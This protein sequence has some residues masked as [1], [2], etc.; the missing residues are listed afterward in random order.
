MILYFARMKFNMLVLCLLFVQLFKSCGISKQVE[1]EVTKLNLNRKKLTEIPPYVYDLKNLKELHLYGNLIDSI[2]YRIGDL[3]NLEKLYIGRNN[4]KEIP[5]EIGKLKNLKILSAQYNEISSLPAEIGDL[6]NLDQLILNQNELHVLPSEICKLKKL[7]NLQ[8]KMNWLDSLPFCMG[9]CQSLRFLHLN[10][11]NL[12]EI[13]ESIGRISH[14]QELYLSGAGFLVR[15]P[16]SF[17]NLR[18]LE[19]LEIDVQTVVPTC[20]LVRQTT[21]LTIIQK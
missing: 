9:D 7:E 20:L 14:L 11:N 3:T 19:I 8:L 16:D 21:R 17:C 10:R 4:L 13:P 2:S 1:S 5:K 18:L 15:L 6:E 12:H